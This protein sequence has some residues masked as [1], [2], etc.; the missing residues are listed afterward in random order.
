MPSLTLPQ[1]CLPLDLTISGPTIGVVGNSY[2]FTA[3]VGPLTTTLPLSYTWQTTAHS[4]ITHTDGLTDTATYMWS[5]TGVQT[6][7][8]SA[9]NS[10]GSAISPVDILRDHD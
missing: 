3:T 8:V 6:M 4:P 5:V 10:Q 7:T 9:S 1:I 2:L